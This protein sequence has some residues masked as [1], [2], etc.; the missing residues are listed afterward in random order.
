[1]PNGIIRVKGEYWKATSAGE[2]I[3]VGENL[4]IVVLDGLTLRV[5]RN[6]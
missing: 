6:K 3:V 5:R 4:E 2:N 1:M